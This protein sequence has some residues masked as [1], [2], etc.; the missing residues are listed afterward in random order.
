MKI[1]REG[2]ESR[3]YDGGERLQSKSKNI[4]LNAGRAYKYERGN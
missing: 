1:K 2:I 3:N 4:S